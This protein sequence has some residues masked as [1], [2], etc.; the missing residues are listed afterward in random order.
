MALAAAANGADALVEC[1]SCHG[2][3]IVPAGRVPSSSTF[4]VRFWLVQ[5]P[6]NIIGVIR[7][8]LSSAHPFNTDSDHFNKGG[9]WDSITVFGGALEVAT[10]AAKAIGYQS[11]LDQDKQETILALWSKGRELARACTWSVPKGISERDSV[12]FRLQVS[13][14][15]FSIPYDAMPLSKRLKQSNK[16]L[17][18]IARGIATA[19]HDIYCLDANEYGVLL[20]KDGDNE[21]DIL[22]AMHLASLAA[23]VEALHM[24]T[25]SR[26]DSLS[27]YAVVASSLLPTYGD[28]F[29]FLS[30]A[31]SLGVRTEELLKAAS[32]LWGGGYKGAHMVETNLIGIVA[33]HCTILMEFIRDPLQFASKNYTNNFMQLLSLWRGSVPI[34]SRDPQTGL[35]K[36]KE[37]HVATE[38]PHMSYARVIK[39]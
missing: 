31:L 1:R 28:L 11:S 34:L 27:H 32:K 18:S 38:R 30:R 12:V 3:R 5:P 24:I 36:S 17:K 29:S 35:C 13:E 21:P 6:E 19:V 22:R 4:L 23:A 16:H 8:S 7:N 9:V 25:Y 39:V 2:I 37:A 20:N 14:E 33:H 10:W 26:D 15:N